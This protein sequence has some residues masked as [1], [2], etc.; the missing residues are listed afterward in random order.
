MYNDQTKLFINGLYQK[1]LLLVHFTY[2][3]FGK[4]N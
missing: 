1:K 3:T 2:L 4:L